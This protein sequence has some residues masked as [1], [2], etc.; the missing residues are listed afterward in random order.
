MRDYLAF[1]RLT[2][3]LLCLMYQ[4]S[5]S[6][7]AQVL[8]AGFSISVIN[9]NWNMVEGIAF[10][11]TGQLYVW[12]KGGKVWVVD[13]NGIKQPNPLIDI[14][15]E[16]GDWRDHGLNGF[17][18]H[19]NF[20]TNGYFYLYYAV[21]MHYLKYFGTPQYHPDSNEYFKATICRITR[22]KASS[23]S[24]FKST[25]AGSRLVLLGETIQTG[26][27]IL[28]ESHSGGSLVFGKDGSLL[29]STGDGASYGYTD[30]GN[31]NSFWSQALSDS[32]IKTKENV[33]SFRSQL[34]DSHNGKILRINPANGNGYASNPY[35]KPASPRSPKSRVWCLGLRNPYR[36]CINPGS[37]S[38]SVT[39]AN[40]GVLLIGDVGWTEREDLN[41]ADKPGLNFGWP[42]FEGL[43]KSAVYTA[44][45]VYNRDAINPLYGSGSCNKNFF[46]FK[47]LCIQ[48][49]NTATPSFPN[50]CN[51]SVQIPA[52]IP[53]FK[54]TGPIIDW[55][56]NVAEART[57]IWNGTSAT[58]VSL[59]DSLSPI[60]G[61][62]FKGNCS[63]GGM[64][65]TGNLY[66]A[67]YKNTYFH[68]DLGEGWIKNI[69]F[70]SLNKPVSIN[71]FASGITNIVCMA[72]NPA[73]QSIYYVK[74][75]D[76]V[77]KISYTP[78]NNAPM[79]VAGADT[80][81]GMEPLT[82]Q[83]T[84]CNS[85][86]PDGDSLNYFWSFGDGSTS[87][88][89][90]PLHVFNSGNSFAFKD[91]VVLVV[92]DSAANTDTA[93]IVVYLNNT[94]PQ[95]NITS[96]NDSDLYTMSG[97]TILPLF[98]SVY[99]A[100]HPV[101]QLTWQWQNILHHNNHSHPEPYD[102]DSVTYTI[103]SPAGCDTANVFYYE[104]QLKVTDDGGLST[105]V[106]KN[107]F[108][109]CTPPVSDFSANKFVSCANDSILFF[110]QSDLFPDSWQWSFPGGIPSSSTLQNP[111]VTYPVAGNYNVSLTTTNTR[112]SHVLIKDS[113][114]T[115]TNGLSVSVNPPGNDTVCKGV[116][117]TLTAVTLPDSSIS[118]QWLKNNVVIAGA[119]MATYDAITQGN[120]K[121][122][123]SKNI[124]GCIG[125][126]PVKKL[127]NMPIDVS[128]KINGPI[129]FC[130][131]SVTL[132]VR[133]ILSNSFQWKKNNVALPGETNHEILIKDP[134]TYKVTVTDK[135]G[136]T[137]NSESVLVT[138]NCKT[139][140]TGEFDNLM[141]EVFPNP[142]RDE[143][144]LKLN[145]IKSEMIK[146]DALDFSTQQQVILKLYNAP[147]TSEAFIPIDVSQLKAGVYG[148]QI[149]SQWHNAVLKLL[150]S[151]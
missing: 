43:T 140:E 63:I 122:T 120:F 8:P 145:L 128:L 26:I 61:N 95:V 76:K 106:S 123:A 74:Y 48:D 1:L 6:V 101:S 25:V 98:A 31:G 150:I 64:W 32:I 30:G 149:T 124:P 80:I 118:F 51:P 127:V 46:E 129:V 78:I 134:G 90:N 69:V 130:N 136:C 85:T 21:D 62:N 108:P 65:Y 131:D 100:E 135:Y 29:V 15:E 16:V 66:P 7:Y 12:E 17:A 77:Y 28:H 97:N 147:E 79:A 67:V 52:G 58:Q 56:H 53:K 14:H 84:G 41:V 115:I 104:I 88:L 33:G 151:K 4:Y 81:F 75:P 71:D 39:A 116:P 10:D 49:T 47:Q 83:F 20:R 50:P 103:L 92:S 23:S 109:S 114:I 125:T 44:L 96:F 87:T 86:D 82:V 54:Q 137:K 139:S 89:A 40:P 24:N 132:D 133:N 9:G 93:K 18:L 111:V 59:A 45:T 105:L 60:Q 148:L 72:Y 55:R 37:G 35:Y 142:A 13:T 113:L 19:P 2:I 138:S 34:I 146:V 3:G 68:A 119:N 117:V 27:P 121:V 57:Q 36:M 73:N 99:D 144:L 102:Y 42:L 112:G 22:Y 11:S 107:L 91:T 94:P 110:D 38:T 5:G 143:I 70:D 141:P 126:S